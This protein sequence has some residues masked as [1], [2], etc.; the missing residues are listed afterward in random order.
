MY[1]LQ[2]TIQILPQELFFFFFFFF[3]RMFFVQCGVFLPCGGLNF[4]V[5]GLCGVRM[6][7]FC[8]SIEWCGMWMG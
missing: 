8:V 4:V 1:K 7:A 3:K 6:W 2:S 5:V